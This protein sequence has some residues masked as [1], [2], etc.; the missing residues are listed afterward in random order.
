[1][2]LIMK[3]VIDKMDDTLEE[4]EFY[5]LHHKIHKESMP[6]LA[7][8]YYKLAQDHLAHY[9]SLHNGVVAIINDYRRTKGE[10]PAN[11][12]AIWSY[13]HEKLVEEYEEIKKML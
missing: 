7:D 6:I 9:L 11:M 8:I 10:P 13:E 3:E 4:A 5:A 12:T 1:M 2:M